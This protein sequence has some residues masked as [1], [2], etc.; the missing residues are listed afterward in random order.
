MAFALP[1]LCTTLLLACRFNTVA[2]IRLY[3]G[4]QVSFDSLQISVNDHHMMQRAFTAGDSLAVTFN[5]HEVN[6]KHDVVFFFAAYA[7]GK[8]VLKTSIFSNDLGHVPDR[9]SF[10]ITD[11]MQV[12]YKE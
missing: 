2:T 1:V 7:G 10:I 5:K 12:K 6:A 8:K 9:V 4:S 3:N 11:S